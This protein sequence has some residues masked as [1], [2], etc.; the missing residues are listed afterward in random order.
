MDNTSWIKKN[1]YCYYCNFGI[2]TATATYSKYSCHWRLVLCFPM[3]IHK[4]VGNFA[5]LKEATDKA[6]F[7]VSSCV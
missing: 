1:D 3:N 5:T 6:V 2:C 4:H 7:L